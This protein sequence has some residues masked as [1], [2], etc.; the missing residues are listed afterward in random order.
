MLALY[1][2]GRQAE[3]LEVYQ[4]A[5]ARFIDELGIDPGPELKRLQSEILRHEVG[6]VGTDAR[7]RRTRRPRS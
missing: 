4:D 6:L 3:A 5:R 1:R 2:A 7:R